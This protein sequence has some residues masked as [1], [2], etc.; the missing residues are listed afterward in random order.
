[1]PSAKKYTFR[2]RGFDYPTVAY[3]CLLNDKIIDESPEL[4]ESK[5]IHN[6]NLLESVQHKPVNSAHGQ[7]AYPTLFTKVAAIGHEIAHGHIFNNGNKRTA[8]QTMVLTLA[9]NDYRKQPN[10]KSMELAVLLTAAGFLNVDGLR[11]ALLY[12]YGLDEK[13]QTL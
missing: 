3:L 6:Q 4:N 9:W 2:H 11:M 10:Q 5:G 13:D 7:D 12:A 8:I 1:M